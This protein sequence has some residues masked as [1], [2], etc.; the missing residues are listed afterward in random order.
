FFATRLIVKSLGTHEYGIYSLV[1]GFIGYSFVFSIG[2]AITKYVAGY[3]STGESG[4]IKDIISATFFI[5]LILGLIGIVSVFSLSGWLVSDVLNMEPE[6]RS[7]TVIALYIASATIFFTLFT[8]VFSAIVQ[9]LH[10][11]DIY[12]KILNFSG[13]SMLLGNLIIAWLGGGLIVLF[14]WNLFIT[15]VTCVLFYLSAKRLL[16]DFSVTHRFNKDSLKLVV[17]FSAGVVG[18]QILGNLWLLFERIWITRTLGTESLTHY[19]V[20][21]TVSFQ[22]Q[23]FIASLVIVIFPLASELQNDREKLERLY[24]KASK[25]ISMMVVF[26]AATIIVHSRLFLNLWMGAEFADASANLLIIHTISFSLV[27]ILTVSWQMTEG[28]GYPNFYCYLYVLCLL[29]SIPLMIFL[30]YEH[31]NEGVAVGRLVGYAVSFLS[32]YYV[33]K[34]FF[35]RILAGFWLNLLGRLLFAAVASVLVEIFSINYLPHG[36]LSL[37]LSSFL[38]GVTYLSVLWLLGFVT[39]DEKILV[40]N[41]LGK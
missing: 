5:N 18:Y 1:L 9:G 17:G 7:R 12:S 33:E 3:Q 24:T 41:V 19:V 10:R 29:I 2:R 22:I 32:I 25:I 39:E 8:Q 37:F 26:I 16:P 4:K 27:A 15:C 36:W 11:F 31:G 23:Y 6:S 20:P 40:R 21:M 28:L 30:S 14:W 34:W 38:G 35:G 13:I